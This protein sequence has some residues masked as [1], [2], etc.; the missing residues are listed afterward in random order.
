MQHPPPPKQGIDE[1]YAQEA[2]AQARRFFA[3]PKADKMQ[4]YTGLVPNEYVGYHP[5]EAYNRNGW[6]HQGAS[7]PYF[8][9]Y[10]PDTSQLPPPLPQ[11]RKGRKK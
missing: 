9:G 10:S 6:K 2:F 4:V 3:L 7:L 1:K 11:K 8:P 5:M